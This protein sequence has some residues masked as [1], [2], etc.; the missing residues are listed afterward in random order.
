MRRCRPDLREYL[1]EHAGEFFGELRVGSL[2]LVAE[3][4]VTN[5]RSSRMEIRE[6]FRKISDVAAPRRMSVVKCFERE[7]AAAGGLVFRVDLGIRAI[8]TD[9]IIGS[10]GRWSSLRQD[11][12][13]KN[14]GVLRER[15]HRVGAAMARGEVLPAIEVYELRTSLAGRPNVETRSEYYVVDGHHRVASAKKIGVSYLDAHVVLYR[16]SRPVGD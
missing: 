13:P 5:N 15:Y 11:F 10:V 1:R 14:A 6:V 9:R 12:Y 2:P 3:N 16:A 8:P 7:L 4:S